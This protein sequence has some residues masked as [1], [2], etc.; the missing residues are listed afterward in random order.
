MSDDKNKDVESKGT[1][2]YEAK[3]QEMF[4]MA[5]K[6]VEDMIAEAEKKAAKI[7]SN[8]QK[9]IVHNTKTKKK[10]DEPMVTIKLPRDPQKGDRIVSVNGKAWMIQ[11]GVNVQVPLSVYEVIEN[12]DRQDDLSLLY[13]EQL[14]NDFETKLNQLK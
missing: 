11:R 10:K 7:V 6:K 5:S 13:Q 12:S 4:D 8:A 1:V 2:D 14:A 3:L 9:T